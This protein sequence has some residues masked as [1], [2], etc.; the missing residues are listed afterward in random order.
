MYH[1]GRLI[2]TLCDT[3][4]DEQSY[5]DLFWAIH[6]CHFNST[7]PIVCLSNLSYLA[8]RTFYQKVDTTRKGGNEDF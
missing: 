7:Y 8:M 1:C 3:P 2:E 6:V 4:I 5:P